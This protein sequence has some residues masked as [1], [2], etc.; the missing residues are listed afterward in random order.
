MIS[1]DLGLVQWRESARLKRA[2]IPYLVLFESSKLLH[3]FKSRYVLEQRQKVWFQVGGGAAISRMAKFSDSA[4]GDKGLQHKQPSQACIPTNARFLMFLHFGKN[5][6]HV[7]S[8]SVIISGLLFL[9]CSQTHVRA[10]NSLH[11]IPLSKGV[12]LA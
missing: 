6:G 10:S 3:L 8:Q 9:P 5:W 12:F 4:L 2:T 11:C 7:F 1:C